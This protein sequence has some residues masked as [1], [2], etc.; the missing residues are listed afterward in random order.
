MIST[1][2]TALV[3]FETSTATAVAILAVLGFKALSQEK[4]M[5]KILLL[6]LLTLLLLGC[7]GEV[8]SERWCNNLK[9]KP[10]GD[11]TVNEAANYAKHCIF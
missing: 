9:D 4:E 2:I 7:K 8:G 3:A 6:S 11:W 5:K 1:S 10:K